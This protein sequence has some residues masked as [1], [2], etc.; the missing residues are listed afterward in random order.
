MTLEKQ[1]NR[2]TEL[3]KY[4]TQCNYEYYV[5]DK[6]TMPDSVYDKIFRELVKL[7]KDYPE[8]FDPS[9]PTQK[10]GAM[11]AK[12]FKKIEH[13]QPMLS[14][15]N[16]MTDEDLRSFV[17]RC[18]DSCGYYMDLYC[19][20][21]FD[22]LAVELTYASGVLVAAGTRG[23]GVIGEDV[24]ANVKTIKSIPLNLSDIA[25]CEVPRLIDI[26]GEVF[27]SHEVF[28]KLNG[29]KSTNLENAYAN[30]R[31]AAAGSLR[32]LDSRITASRELSFCAYGVGRLTASGDEKYGSYE[33][34]IKLLSDLGIPTSKDGKRLTAT[35]VPS[36]IEQMS[37]KRDKLDYDIDGVVI[38]VNDIS[39]QEKLGNS[40]RAPKWAVAWKFPA[41]EVT[42][43]VEDVE[44]QYSR[45][46]TVTPVAKVTPV[47][48]GG[49]IVSSC[50]LH[51]FDNIKRLDLRIGDTV[52]LKRAGDVIPQITKVVIESRTGNE[53]YVGIPVQCLHCD[54]E[55][56]K[57]DDKVR[58]YC[59]NPRCPDKVFGRVEFFV[60]KKAMNI[61]GVGPALIRT[62]VTRKLVKDISDLY[63][64]DESDL[65]NLDGMGKVS[66]NNIIAA[67]NNNGT[68]SEK[69]FLVALGIPLVGERASEA[70]LKHF[71]SIKNIMDASL[72]AVM[73]VKGIGKEIADNVWK[74][75]CDEENMHMLKKF[76]D[77]QVIDVF[78]GKCVEEKPEPVGIFS[79]RTFLLTGTLEKMTRKQA[80][81]NIMDY[82]G[83]VSNSVS[84]GLDFLIVGDKPGS[85]K[86]VKAE[87]LN[88]KMIT[89]EEFIN[90]LK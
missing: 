29:E 47:E 9:S 89:E 51:N 30:P 56:R 45:T 46:G 6:P 70:L 35:Q 43:V 24:L 59:A 83:S 50:T 71:K 21:K 64:L 3:R 84:K 11:P 52:F 36:Y 7:E 8:Y 33:L 23:D 79:N 90:M 19:E 27:M 22:G 69:T 20:P 5:L 18:I 15:D 40:H 38:K 58:Y 53:I 66:A 65:M 2:I 1:K 76:R 34:L 82:G 37:N 49:V 41:Q 48:V 4:I 26:R 77:Y 54:S 72:K 28:E 80:Y 81:E 32:Q 75:F 44:F 63:M 74:F 31:N 85:A 86:L 17:K 55:L 88:I 25:N 42:T 16:A 68:P 87:K 57:D 60:S 13:A 39:I 14:L 61:I 62:L 73:C 10:V 67:I 78:S 12:K